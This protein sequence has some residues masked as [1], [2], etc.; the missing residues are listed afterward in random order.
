MVSSLIALI[1]GFRFLKWMHIDDFWTT[2]YT[3]LTFI[4][5][6]ISLSIIVAAPLL[7]AAIFTPR[8][9]LVSIS[10]FVS[11]LALTLLV[12]DTFIYDQFR[13][14]LSGFILEL[15]IGAG[16]S[17]FGLTWITW[18]Y[19]VMFQFFIVGICTW[20]SV[21]IFQWRPRK[22]LIKSF[23]L[24]YFLAFVISNS[25]HIWAD[26]HSNSKFTSVGLHLPFYSGLT[27]KRFLMNQGLVDHQVIRKNIE[28]N[29]N[30]NIF[31]ESKIDRALNYPTESVNCK[32]P[33]KLYNILFIVIDT[34]R[35]DM[36][37]AKW[38]P[39][40][41]N[42]AKKSI[43]FK[44]HRSNGNVTKSGV[45]TLFYGIP[46]SYWDSFTS[47]NTPPVFIDRLHELNYKTQILASATLVSPDFNKNIFS[48]IKGLRLEA[49]KSLSWEKDQ[50]IT[51]DWLEFTKTFASEK[52][53]D[54]FFGF[55]FYDS[56]HDTFLPDDYP[57]FKPFWDNPSHLLLHNDF[58]PEPYLNVY[59]TTVHYTDSLVK[60]VLDDLKK[61]NL[62]KDT[63]VLITSDHGQEFNEHKL[64]FWGHGSNFSDYQIKVPLVIH[65]PGKTAR[66]ITKKTHH[67]DVI[68]TL[69][70]D[71]LGCQEN[72]ISQYSSGQHLFRKTIT[73]W[74][75]VHS[76]TSYGLLY[77]DLILDQPLAG[78]AKMM[79][80]DLTPVEK[81]ILPRHIIESL[82]KELSKFYNYD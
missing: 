37:D 15:A 14:H 60:K 67:F 52:K 3:I 11:S 17:I 9:I 56:P 35:S 55:L 69:M 76:Y 50:Q 22:W 81:Q 31:N 34:L 43:N 80:K 75:L 64:N 59:R 6:F 1:I 23:L 32:K 53:P 77:E 10:V 4:S 72:A 12:G 18:I 61:R 74:S 66:I 44:Q 47:S 45:F 41:Y 68:P 79:K 57:R 13:F 5:H 73:P 27:A 46:A 62:L 38:M 2:C 8:Y 24:S 71:S 58:D 54:P 39:N 48:S 20:L 25:W 63:I 65:W 40:T 16:L 33:R 82:F 26:A 36:L 51:E 70:T 78:P 49:P 19:M 42:F 30:K 28:D 29:K 21:K 7:L